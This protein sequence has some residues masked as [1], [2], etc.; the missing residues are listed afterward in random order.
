MFMPQAQQELRISAMTMGSGAAVGRK[1]GKSSEVRSQLF[2]IDP[3]GAA[4][5]LAGSNDEVVFDV[6]KQP[7]LSS[8]SLLVHLRPVCLSGAFIRSVGSIVKF[9]WSRS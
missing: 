1:R 8:G 3:Q 6:L 2:R 4:E 5:V 9:Q 7:I